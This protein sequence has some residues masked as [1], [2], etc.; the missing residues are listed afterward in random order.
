M[1][2]SA[3]LS[4]KWPCST[5]RTAASASSGVLRT[6]GTA[7]GSWSAAS[8]SSG[9]A[10]NPIV[11][12][13]PRSHFADLVT[14]RLYARQMYGSGGSFCI[15]GRQCKPDGICSAYGVRRLQMSISAVR[16]PQS[17]DNTASA[18][19][20][21]DRE[22]TV[23]ARKAAWALVVPS[24]R[25]ATTMAGRPHHR[26]RRWPRPN[27]VARGAGVPPGRGLPA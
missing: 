15:A 2:V 16:M 11:A 7:S 17:S 20:A 22:D 27:Y 12:I 18:A 24:A 9:D 4:V 3:P 25:A 14:H 1:Q 8:K 19:A 5:R 23:G 26:L 6:C 10:I 21:T 13:K